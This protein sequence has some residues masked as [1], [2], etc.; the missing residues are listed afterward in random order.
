MD[1]SLRIF[2][3]FRPFLKMCRR[4]T[5]RKD[6]WFLFPYIRQNRLLNHLA[7]RQRSRCLGVH[8][9][10]TLTNK[11]ILSLLQSLQLRLYQQ[12]IQI[13]NFPL[14][15]KVPWALRASQSCFIQNNTWILIDILL[16]E[17]PLLL[18][19]I[20]KC[21]E[22]ILKLIL[23]VLIAT[24]IRSLVKTIFVQRCHCHLRKRCLSWLL[25]IVL[26]IK[27]FHVFLKSRV[28]L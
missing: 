19:L 2:D 20:L 6:G 25:F 28:L 12:R 9:F 16:I 1:N 7:I 26:L 15:F 13:V 14:H 17:L 3:R 21:F 10:E 23:K 4:I 18:F 24:D 11:R 5:I 22:F 8:Y 27:F